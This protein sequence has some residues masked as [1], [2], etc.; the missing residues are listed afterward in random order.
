MNYQTINTKVWK[1]KTQFNAIADNLA[2][3]IVPGHI[4]KHKIV[5]K[6]K[7]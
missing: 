3:A 6:D 5:K 1:A 2:V 4:T 7:Y